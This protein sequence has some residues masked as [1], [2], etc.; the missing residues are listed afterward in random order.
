M[1][2][3]FFN[4]N[5]RAAYKPSG[6]AAQKQHV[7][8]YALQLA[9]PEGVWDVDRSYLYKNMENAVH[10]LSSTTAVLNLSA[11]LNTA[12]RD[13]RQLIRVHMVPSGAA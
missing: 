8:P 13:L 5:R 1:W 10:K 11:L 6:T 4:I 12:L 7:L 2:D 9:G 3:L